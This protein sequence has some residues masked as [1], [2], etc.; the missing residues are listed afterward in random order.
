[1]ETNESAMNLTQETVEMS[2]LDGTEQGAVL[3][4]ISLP[5][6]GKKYEDMTLK[7]CAG[8]LYVIVNALHD[9]AGILERS[10]SE[11]KLTS[12]EQELFLIHAARC[13]KIAKKFSQQ[14]GYDY[15]KALERCR[16][17]RTRV[18]GSGD[19]GMDGL[20]AVVKKHIRE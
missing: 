15:D 18:K 17:R 7:T 5:K 20:E 16:N 9:Y 1:M 8:D 14:M 11:R 10:A 12:Y 19:T 3:Q 6:G 4:Y 2:E 13:R